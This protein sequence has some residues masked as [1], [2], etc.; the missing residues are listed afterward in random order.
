MRFRLHSLLFSL[1]IFLV[2][3][4]PTL[5]GPLEDC[6]ECAFLGVPGQ[7]GD[8]LF[9]TVNAGLPCPLFSGFTPS[10]S[11]LPENRFGTT[12]QV[13]VLQVKM[14]HFDFDLH[15]CRFPCLQDR[16]YQT[17]SARPVILA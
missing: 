5:S 2:L 9:R 16:A 15:L 6:A 7:D 8:L 3:T 13:S 10:E 11:H 17:A 4:S 12:E 1:S 14:G